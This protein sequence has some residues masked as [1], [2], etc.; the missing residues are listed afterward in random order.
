MKSKLIYSYT[1]LRTPKSLIFRRPKSPGFLSIFKKIWQW[2]S[3]PAA[4][5]PKFEIRQ[6]KDKSGSVTWDVY[7]PATGYW[8]RFSSE[9]EVRIWIEEWYYH[10][11]Y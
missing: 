11:N 7:E 6:V 2:L 8:A 9:E 5:N 10:Q 3:E 1:D 4:E